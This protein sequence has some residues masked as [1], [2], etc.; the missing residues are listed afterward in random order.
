MIYL[1]NAATSN[2]KP[3][4]VKKAVWNALSHPVN[5]GRNSGRESFLYA[6]KILGVRESIAQLLHIEYSENIVF[7][8][9]ASHGLNLAIKGF[10]KPNDHVILTLYE[11][12][13]VLRQLYQKEKNPICFLPCYPDHRVNFEQMEQLIL[14]N[15]ALLVV[16]AASNVTGATVDYKKIYQ[17][18]NQLGLTV[19]FDFSQAIGNI[20]IDLSECKRCM[21]VFSGHKSLLGPQGTGVLYVSPDI[22]L[23]PVLEG[24]TG[25]LSNELFQPDFLPDQLEIGTLNVPGILGLGKGV[26]F[27]KA[28]K[29][30]A[31]LHH[32]LELIQYTYDALQNMKHIKVYHNGDFQNSV[33]ILSFNVSNAHSELIARILSEKYHISTRG[34]YHCAPFAHRE[35]GTEN[36]GAVRVSPGYKT[37]KKEMTKLLDAIYKIQKNSEY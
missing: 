11:H 26:E 25:S 14:P 36:Q 28:N 31:L 29:P 12:N 5:V 3:Y 23:S 32:K 35:L 24:G 18:A 30:E 7:T 8:S 16:N 15:T 27:V 9:N 17:K 22:A 34:G 13:S 21:A 19:L 2:Q 1:D 20:D 10:L 37:T 4:S 33:G 6:E